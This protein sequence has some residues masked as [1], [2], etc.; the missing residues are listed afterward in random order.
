DYFCEGIAEEIINTLCGVSGMRVASRSA[1]FQMKNRAMDSREVGRLLNV[2]S[3][4]EGSVRK[5]GDRLRITAQLINA[6]DGFH[7]WSQTFERK[8]EDI[9]AVQ[10]EI[11]LHIVAALRV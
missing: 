2:Q 3:F 1:A 6:A 5:S 7:L 9:F 11:G 4:L 8:L 10:E